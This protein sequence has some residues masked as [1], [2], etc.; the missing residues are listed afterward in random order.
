MSH[1]PA[2]QAAPQ[3]L[4]RLDPAERRDHVAT[5]HWARYEWAA[6]FL[7]RGRVLD[8]ACGVGYGSALLAERGAGQVVGVDV[9][10]EA[11]AEAR[12]R[13]PRTNVEYVQ[14]DALTL[15]PE[16]HGRFDLIVCLETI[17]HLAE[18]RRLLSV[19][20]E[21]LAPGGLLAL[22]CPNDAH[23][24]GHNPY[25]LWTAEYRQLYDWLRAEFAHVASWAEAHVVGTT[26]WPA[27]VAAQPEP[28]R[29]YPLSVRVVDELAIER[30]A[31][32]LFGCG[33]KPAPEGLMRGALQLDGFNY[34][35]ELEGTV[36]RLWD[37][38]RRLAG[39]NEKLAAELEQARL[40]GAG[41]AAA[42]GGQ[43]PAAAAHPRELDALR[44]QRDQFAAEA[45]RV[46]DA[47]NEQRRR[48]GE[49]EAER[50]RIWADGRQLSRLYEQQQA[51]IEQQSRELAALREELSAAQA[52]TRRLAEAWETQTTRLGVAERERDGLWKQ[53]QELHARLQAA[54][55][56]GE[57]LGSVI[58]H[59]RQRRLY[60]AMARLGLLPKVGES[61]PG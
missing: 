25:H 46:A 20:A 8:C 43:A 4:E 40:A 42:R 15:T 53:F 6:Q 61:K 44:A 54:E 49:V 33:D 59:V 36:R 35:R 14:A 21:L 19:F 39:D 55:A 56:A 10:D 41:P 16:R 12:R 17:E 32:F 34:M 57:R 29:G 1:N 30:A 2:Q 50:D 9:S 52:E 5:Q 38:A 13:Y 22:S 27:A 60:R 24:G 18:P 47:W 48:L 37:E 45:R 7:P 3:A 51:H 31:G 11:L 28:G 26:V 58:E 23:L